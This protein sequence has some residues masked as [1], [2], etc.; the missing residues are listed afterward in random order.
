MEKVNVDINA[1][2]EVAVKDG[3]RQGQTQPQPAK[4]F[5]VEEC[6]IKNTQ[7]GESRNE[8]AAGENGNCP[9]ASHP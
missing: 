2:V 9:G 8:A 5:G 3:L 4:Q 1:N 6:Q 7:G